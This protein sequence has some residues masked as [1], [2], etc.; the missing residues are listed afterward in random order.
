MSDGP[1][2][3]RSAAAIRRHVL[4]E[5]RRYSEPRNPARHLRA[6]GDVARDVLT[7]MGVSAQM[8]EE[9][10]R[11]GWA[12]AVGPFLAAHSNPLSLRAG[13]LTVR[14]VQPSVRYT[15]EQG[16]KRDLLARLQLR[17][18]PEAIRDLAFTTA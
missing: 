6:A 3:F 7:A 12:E 2:P 17:F 8:D 1:R 9:T 18:G 13:I 14:V 4:A 5:W 10:V 16:M 11:A 15:L